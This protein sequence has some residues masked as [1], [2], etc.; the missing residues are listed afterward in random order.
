[1]ALEVAVTN[2]SWTQETPKLSLELEVDPRTVAY[3]IGKGKSNL[4][5]IGKQVMTQTGTKVFI[6]YIKP[7]QSDWGHFSIHSYTTEAIEVARDLIRESESKFLE[8]KLDYR[9]H[10][11]HDDFHPKIS[12]D[13]ISKSN[14]NQFNSHHPNGRP[15]VSRPNVSRPNVSRP[16][17]SRPNVS[18]PNVSR[19]N[20]SRPNVSRPN[21][22]RPNV[23]R[24]NVSR[25][26]NSFNTHNRRDPRTNVPQQKN[27]HRTVENYRHKREFNGKRRLDDL[28]THFSWEG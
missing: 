20:V 18:R 10:Q 17:V 3:C 21:V 15:N 25:H 23:S 24:P 16:N 12:K 26:N 28:P 19:P 1:M 22:S 6:K 2:A 7:Q 4:R 11:V 8:N 5:E 27:P 13:F 14:S 9:I